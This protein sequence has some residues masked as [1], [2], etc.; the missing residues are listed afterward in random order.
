VTLP[1]ELPLTTRSDLLAA[2]RGA[3]TD[4]WS[5]DT[6]VQYSASAGELERFNLTL[7]RQPAPGKVLNFGYRYTRDSLKQVDLSTQWPLSRRLVGL[8]R[9]NYSLQGSQLLQGLLGLEYNA[10]CWTMRFVAQRFVVAADQM[11]SGM[12]IQFELG[13]LSRIGSNPFEVLRQNIGGYVRPPMRPLPPG[14][15]YPGMDE[16]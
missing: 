14:D 4:T 7:Q 13:G 3:L 11:S 8:A 15:Y 1:G 5:V 16:P 9:W 10:G 2:L 6:G 12:F